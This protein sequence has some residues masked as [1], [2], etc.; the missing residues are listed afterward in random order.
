MERAFGDSK[1]CLRVFSFFKTPS[2]SSLY[3]GNV[4][5]RNSGESKSNGSRITQS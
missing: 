5:G 1:N 4:E 3:R 2:Y